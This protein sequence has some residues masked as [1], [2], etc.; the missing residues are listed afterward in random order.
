MKKL[1]VLTA[2]I[3]I[4]GIAFAQTLQKGSLIGIHNTSFSLNPDVELKEFVD[5]QV[6][7]MIPA[8]EKNFVG[9]KLFIMKGDRGEEKNGYA[10]MWYF[11]SVKERDIYFTAE[12]ELTEKGSAAQEKLS[13]LIEEMSKFGSYTTTHTDW[14]IL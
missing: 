5:F 9:V 10:F 2:F 6:N 8:V 14:V 12:G 7:K 4:A 1:I 13:P 11:K 3:L